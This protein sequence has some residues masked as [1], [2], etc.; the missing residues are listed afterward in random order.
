M[1]GNTITIN[2]KVLPQSGDICYQDIICHNCMIHKFEYDKV[3]TELENYIIMLDGVILNR[4]ELIENCNN[5]TN[6]DGVQWSDV[7]IN[8]YEG[9][10]EQ[11]VASLRGSFAGALYDK[12]QRKWIIFG[13]QIGS[14][15]V[16]FAKI[17][18]FFCCTQVMGYMYQMLRDNGMDY[19]LDETG[20]WMLLTYGYMLDNVT[21]C[22]EV[23]KINPGCYITLQDGKLE[24]H[25]YYMLDNSPDTTLNEQDAIELIDC[26]FRKA[27]IEE[28]EKDKECKYR[29]LVNLSG[30]LDCRMTSFVAHDCGYTDQI[31]VTFSQTGYWDQTLPM[32]MSTAMKHEWIFK[33]LDNGLWLY[34]LDEVTRTTGGN[35]LYY[36]TAHGN[37]LYKYLNF[38]G[39]GIDHTGQIGDVVIGSFV[40]A[41]EKNRKYSIGDRAYSNKYLSHLYDFKPLLYDVNK[42]IGLFYYRAL[43]GTNNG[44]QNS[45][46]FTETLSPFLELDFLEKALSIP[47]E[48]RQNHYIYKKWILAKYP[49]AAEFEW[50]TTGRKITDVLEE[51]KPKPN[52]LFIPVLFKKPIKKAIKVIRGNK[53]VTQKVQDGPV[54]MNPID[55]YLSHNQELFNFLM[56]YFQ[57]VEAVSD[58]EL[59]KVLLEIKTSG[60]AVEKIQAVSLLG[61]I[62][63]FYS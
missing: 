1:Y 21:L 33:A 34:D 63:L 48:M 42:E 35:V 39:F 45:Y 56:G 26:Y 51:N 9:K 58:A 11:F 50:E 32:R 16:Y 15:F 19:H 4:K 20:A 18:D 23:R 7:L 28:F 59:E 2:G 38:N 40:K 54:G 44:L 60:T 25:R 52:S 31:N 36:G 3:F 12:R 22:R 53:N 30:G 55:Y 61:A 49:Q 47:L 5:A 41:H 62:K 27:I 8:L 13:D 57:Y 24:E 43:H 6:S 37:S 14:K 29:H 17:G 10:G 46:N